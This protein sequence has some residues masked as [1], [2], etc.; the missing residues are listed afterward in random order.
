ML[1]SRR[2]LVDVAVLAAFGVGLLVAGLI[3]KAPALSRSQ[4]DRLADAG[5]GPGEPGQDSPWQ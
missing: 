1:G 4:P 2:R 5:P 3:L